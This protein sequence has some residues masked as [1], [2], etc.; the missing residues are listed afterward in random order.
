[1]LRRNLTQSAK[2]A[3][4]ISA[5]T[6]AMH[7][8]IYNEADEMFTY[9]KE[10]YPDKRDIRKVP[11]FLCLTTGVKTMNAHY[12]KNKISKKKDENNH[13]KDNMVLEIQ[14]TKHDELSTIM[15]KETNG[16][17]GELA[18]CIPDETNAP[19]G[20]LANIIPDKTNAP[21]GELA[22][23]IPD[24]TNAPTGEL[25]N[26]IPDETNAPT[27]ELANIIPDDIYQGLLEELSND[28][29]LSRIFN[30][31]DPLEEDNVI[32]E[33]QSIDEP[34]P[35]EWELHNLGY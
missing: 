26:I 20:E 34:T 16:P 14:L 27:G 3:R 9:L 28:P 15:P 4:F 22:S 23:C 12:Y 5:Y 33:Y 11:E 8:D 30:G 19:T 6:E 35:L 25:A 31:F 13:N 17:T 24:E 18:S 7:P 21:T 32:V 1:M 2:R 10:A 29:D